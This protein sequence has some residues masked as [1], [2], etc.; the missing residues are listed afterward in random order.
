MGEQGAADYINTGD[1]ETSW[2]R[3]EEFEQLEQAQQN[4][5]AVIIATVATLRDQGVPL[6]AWATGIG[7]RFSAA[8]GE[9]EPWDANEFLDAM[10][11]ILQALGAE[12]SWADLADPTVAS[13]TIAALFDDE[14][15]ATF[16]TTRVNA[17]T[18]LDATSGI[19]GPRGLVWEWQID[20]D[21]VQVKVRR[22]ET[23]TTAGPDVAGD[24]A[25]G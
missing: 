24:E 2:D 16:G 9:P 5:Q 1:F 7:Q 17:L 4:A 19:A 12:V 23:A 18:Y 3:H 21:D 25:G 11:S 14:I 6:D 10:L 20:G 13:A 15:C 8:W 22:V